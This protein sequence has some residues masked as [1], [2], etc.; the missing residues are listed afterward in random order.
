MLKGMMKEMD[1]N[2]VK[3]TKQEEIPAEISARIDTDLNEMQE[4]IKS[5]HAEIRSTRDEWLVDL[6]DGR[7]EAIA[8]NEATE[9]ELNP[10]MMHS[11]V[12]NQ[13]IPEGEAAVMPVREPRKR[14]RVYNLPAERRQKRKERTREN[15][16]SRRKSAAACM[17][18]SHRVKMAW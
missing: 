7:K 9:T 1:I 4:D 5:G 6:K 16:G 18:V 2:Q 10:G 8:C 14:R 12:E 13:E 15:R 3:A 17:K 11:T